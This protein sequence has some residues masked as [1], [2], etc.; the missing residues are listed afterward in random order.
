MRQR[1]DLA[2]NKHKP[3]L[4]SRYSVTISNHHI[5]LEKISQFLYGL[6]TNKKV[7]RVCEN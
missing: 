4:F 3:L 7:K 6:S 1:L 5:M 2:L